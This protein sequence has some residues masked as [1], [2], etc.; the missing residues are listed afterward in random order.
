MRACDMEIDKVP[1]I[2]IVDTIEE[3]SVKLQLDMD[4][5]AYTTLVRIGKEEASDD[6][7]FKIGFI[8]VMED[9]IAESDG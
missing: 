4:D 3:E 9:Y 8:K 5:E 1:V 2:K 6:D 7:F